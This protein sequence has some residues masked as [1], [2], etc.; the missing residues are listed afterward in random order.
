MSFRYRLCDFS[1]SLS[2]LWCNL[3]ITLVKRDES[4]FKRL[5]TLILG[6]LECH[7][8]EGC[9]TQCCGYLDLVKGHTN[10]P[11][12]I[13][14]EV[15][16]IRGLVGDKLVDKNL[17]T[18]PWNGLPS[19][20]Y[21]VFQMSPSWLSGSSFTLVDFGHRWISQLWWV[22]CVYCITW[23]KSVKCV[24]CITRDKS[25]GC[26]SQ[27]CGYL[28]LTYHHQGFPLCHGHRG[29]RNQSPVKVD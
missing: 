28:D 26:H 2:S 19:R 1:L 4:W 15:L 13:T 12:V 8:P 9:S 6:I 20:L 7:P 14:T 17:S 11:C 22:K 10:S 21:H 29:S 16:E 23:D 27:C 25:E 18:N 5:T 24:C 3:R